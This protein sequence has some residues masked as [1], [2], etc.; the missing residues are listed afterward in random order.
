M[1]DTIW[2]AWWSHSHFD[3]TGQHLFQNEPTRMEVLL[4]V[5]CDLGIPPE[6]QQIFDNCVQV[7]IEKLQVIRN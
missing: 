4:H 5:M 1:N 6:D 3:Y 2:A 7:T